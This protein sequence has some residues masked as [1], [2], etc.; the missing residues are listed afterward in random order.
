M[1]NVK[2]TSIISRY[3]GLNL[4]TKM[5][6][7]TFESVMAKF[8]TFDLLHG[9]LGNVIQSS[10]PLS[11]LYAAGCK[12]FLIAYQGKSYDVITENGKEQFEKVI[13]HRS[14]IA[15]CLYVYR[16]LK[17]SFIVILSLFVLLVG[18]SVAFM[19]LI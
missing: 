6:L 2:K 9:K 16:N 4:S 5:Y 12:T 17:N 3:R 1:F 18:V 14:R 11:F 13:V 7:K 8:V 15:G 19:F 10:V